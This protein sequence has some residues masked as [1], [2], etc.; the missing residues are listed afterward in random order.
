[1]W[2]ELSIDIFFV[3][4]RGFGN[5]KKKIELLQKIFLYVNNFL[6]SDDHKV[7][8]SKLAFKQLLTNTKIKGIIIITTYMLKLNWK[9]IIY[10]N[11]SE[12]SKTFYDQISK[13][14]DIRWTY[15]IDR[16]KNLIKNSNWLLEHKKIQIYYKFLLRDNFNMLNINCQLFICKKN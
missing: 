15:L 4:I 14:Y 6:N 7:L 1:M 8:S 16:Y 9:I 3:L 5:F 13:M 2:K 10:V 11:L 12:E